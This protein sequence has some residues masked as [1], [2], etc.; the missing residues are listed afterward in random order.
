[1]IGLPCLSFTFRVCVSKFTALREIFRLEKKG[2]T[3]KK[4]LSLIEPTYFPN[5]LSTRLLLGSI[6]T[7]P[8]RIINRLKNKR[9]I[10]AIESPEELVATRTHRP[11]MPA[12]INKATTNMSQPDDGFLTFS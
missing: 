9:T 10:N 4:P 2:L 8:E 7:K 1:M 11:I 3:Q 6:A 12:I 5:R